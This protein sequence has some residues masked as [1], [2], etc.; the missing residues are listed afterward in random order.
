MLFAIMAALVQMELDIRRACVVDSIAKRRE[1]SKD[2]GGRP[3]LITD[4]H[5]RNARRVIDGE[6]FATTVSR[7][8]GMSRA[9]FYRRTRTLELA[10]ALV[11]KV[12][13]V[14]AGLT[15][16]ALT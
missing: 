7:D 10:A 13:V 6:E 16:L 11:G 5:I 14:P 1:A 8:L 4:R 3:R 15:L 12:W 2:L 9:A